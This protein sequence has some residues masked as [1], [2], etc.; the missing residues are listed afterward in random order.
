VR[1]LLVLIMLAGVARAEEPAVR[2]RMAAAA[3]EGTGWAREFH[4]LARELAEATRGRVQMKWVL[5]GIAG[6]E[7]QQLDRI[8][9][10][11]LD[12]AAG[13]M[14]C[15]RLAPTM[16]VGRI[17]GLFQTREE[18]RFV[19]SRLLRDIDAEFARAGFVNLGVG[20]FGNVILFSRKP[21]R[22]FADLRQQRMWTYELDQVTISMLRHMGLNLQPG[23]LDG[24]LKEYDEERVDG[25]VAAAQ[26]ALAFQWSSR[27]RFFSDLVV[28]ELPGCIALAQRTYDQLSLGQR[29]A[30]HQA[31]SKFQARFDELGRLVDDQLM[32]GLFEKQG[33]HRYAAPDALRSEFFEAARAAREQLG[34]TLVPKELLARTLGLL[35][36][37]RSAQQRAR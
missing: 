20:S 31:V 19:M 37:Y 21:L 33:T 32:N 25:F 7:L 22:S 5:G 4:T 34:A 3:P 12:G 36:D 28:N 29:E 24:A 18:W 10:G 26:P 9:R 16:R 17:V 11:Q 35:A 13:A 27:A 2:I 30:L 1:L 15:E 23:S 6:D 14:F 8:Q